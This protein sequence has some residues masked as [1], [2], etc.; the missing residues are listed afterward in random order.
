MSQEGGEKKE[1]DRQAGEG[2]CWR[3]MGITADMRQTILLV[4]KMVAINAHPYRNVCERACLCTAR[5]SV[6]V[7]YVRDECRAANWGYIIAV[8]VGRTVKIAIFLG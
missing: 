4:L 3:E 5:S 2:R 6:R 8:M 7:A 1:E